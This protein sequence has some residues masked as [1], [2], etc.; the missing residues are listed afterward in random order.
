L[1]AR[2]VTERCGVRVLNRSGRCVAGDIPGPTSRRLD[3]GPLGSCRT[4]KAHHHRLSRCSGQRIGF[5]GRPRSRAQNSSAPNHNHPEHSEGEPHDRH[6]QQRGLR[7][8]PR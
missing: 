3:A 7:K 5:A 8:W 1:C 4:R 2:S 6:G